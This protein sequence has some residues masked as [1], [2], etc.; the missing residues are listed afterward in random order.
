MVPNLFSVMGPFDDLAISCGPLNKTS[1][2]CYLQVV[3]NICFVRQKSG[4]LLR[5]FQT[6]AT[7]RQIEAIALVNVL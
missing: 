7:L 4:M 1:Q 3:F 5:T 2:Y 6:V